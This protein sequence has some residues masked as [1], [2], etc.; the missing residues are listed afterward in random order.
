MGR[1]AGREGSSA[2]SERG[3]P[4]QDAGAGSPR[5]FCPRFAPR[6]PAQAAGSNRPGFLFA[7]L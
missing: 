5:A 7:R 6:H 3:K 1:Q 2:A 4:G